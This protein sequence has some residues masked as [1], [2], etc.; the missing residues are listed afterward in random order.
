LGL[1]WEES[2][3]AVGG[4]AALMGECG[5][6]LLYTFNELGIGLAFLLFGVSEQTVH[7]WATLLGA[8]SCVLF[9]RTAALLF[10]RRI[11]LFLTV[12]FATSLSMTVASFIAEESFAMTI[13]CMTGILWGLVS[14]LKTHRLSSFVGLG[15][16]LGVAAMEYAALKPGIAIAPLVLLAAFFAR[17][18]GSHFSLRCL[19]SALVRAGTMLCSALIL[20]APVVVNAWHR[21]SAF[22]EGDR[23]VRM[24]GADAYSFLWSRAPTMLPSLQEHIRQFLWRGAEYPPLVGF[25]GRPPGLLSVCET[26]LFSLSLVAAPVLLLRLVF[27]ARG[28]A[29]ATGCRMALWLSWSAFLVWYCAFHNELV[30]SH[31]LLVCVP[32][33]FLFI[34]EVLKLAATSFA[35]RPRYA[36]SAVV[37]GV[38]LLLGCNSVLLWK[39]LTNTVARAEYNGKTNNL[40]AHLNNVPAVHSYAIG[41]Y[42]PAQATF[43]FGDTALESWQKKSMAEIAFT[44][45]ETYGNWACVVDHLVQLVQPLEHGT[46][47]ILA[48][49]AAARQASHVILIERARNLAETNPVGALSPDMLDRLRNEVGRMSSRVDASR[50]EYIADSSWFLSV[51]CP[52]R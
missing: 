29:L 13:F 52:I 16:F 48:E 10:S 11:S 27:T 19:F 34:G 15:A 44:S 3:A 28:A 1:F 6:L 39:T 21:G 8:L 22:F 14:C 35:V 38:V 5:Y 30:L 20:A 18:V 37:A 42:W 41:Y 12:L 31:R 26:L 23:A 40:C 32:L 49:A 50:C 33:L 36:S 43:F 47:R 46:A 51:V 45:Y 25:V 2:Q 7:L 9:E 4:R 17:L 24:V